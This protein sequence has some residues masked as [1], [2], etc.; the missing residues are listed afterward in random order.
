MRRKSSFFW[1]LSILM[2]FAIA[3]TNCT[4][5]GPAGPAGANGVDGVDGTDGTDGV[6]GNSTC[7]ECHTLAKMEGIAHS[8]AMSQH[9]TGDFVGYAGGR[10]ACAK[11]HS[12]EGFTETLLTG[13]D[14]TAANIPIPTAFNCNT[15]HGSHVSLDPEDGDM[16]PLNGTAPFTLLMD[17]HTTTLDMGNSN[18]CASC[19]QPRTPAPTD[20]G[21]GMYTITSSHYGPHHGPQGTVLQGIG[22]YEVGVGYPE[23]GSD[24]HRQQSSC[25]ACHLT[26]TPDADY[27]GHKF[28]V[29]VAV[30]TSCHEGA[31]DMD[32]NGKQTE[33]EGLTN[34]LKDLLMTQGVLDAEGHVVPGTYTIDQAGAFYNYATVVE[35]RS[36]GVHNYDYCKQLLVNSI[37][38]LQ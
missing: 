15:C 13:M 17:D 26:Y 7:L 22:G 34:T 5:E 21:T 8:Y 18:L 37:N 2:V 32:I 23:P 36:K 29:G 1:M 19:H 31:T 27:G 12:H 35:D 3:M 33:I 30:C 10:S 20:D 25:I 6:D 28:T 38:V 16:T 24:I 4:K 14:T 9:A 11:C